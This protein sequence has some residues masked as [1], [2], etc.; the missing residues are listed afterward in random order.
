MNFCSQLSASDNPQLPPQLASPSLLV[1]GVIHDTARRC[2]ACRSFQNAPDL[3]VKL[4]TGTSR[5]AHSLLL[6]PVEKI[7]GL[8]PIL[9]KGPLDLSQADGMASS[10]AFQPRPAESSCW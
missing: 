10:Y 4:V 7:G 2:P 5:A 3:A 9:Y 1:S 6:I 8:C